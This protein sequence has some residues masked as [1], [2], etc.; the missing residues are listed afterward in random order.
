MGRE[1][2]RN[3]RV[4]VGLD[5]RCES[6]D[7]RRRLALDARQQHFIAARPFIFWGTYLQRFFVPSLAYKN[8]NPVRL[9]PFRTKV[10][11]DEI[12]GVL[13]ITSLHEGRH[14]RSAN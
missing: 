1:E 13:V 4:I 3:F 7:F 2:V 12:H 11:T 6:S 9:G 5:L 8:V 14:A 10:L